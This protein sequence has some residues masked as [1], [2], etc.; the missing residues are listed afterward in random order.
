MLDENRWKLVFLRTLVDE[1]M[2]KRTLQVRVKLKDGDDVC[3]WEHS[4]MGN[5]QQSRH[6]I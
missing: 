5:S 3:V 4:V 2:V 6:G 1:S